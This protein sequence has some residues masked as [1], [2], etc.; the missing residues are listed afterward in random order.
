MIRNPH[1]GVQNE[2][3]SQSDAAAATMAALLA[4]GGGSRGLRGPGGGAAVGTQCG[5]QRGT[6][7]QAGAAAGAEYAG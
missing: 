5:G 4:V 1:S 6:R 3:P 2:R 7:R